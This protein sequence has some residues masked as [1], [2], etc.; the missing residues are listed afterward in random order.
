MDNAM[1]LLDE[2]KQFVRKRTKLVPDLGVILGSGLGSF[3]DTVEEAVVV[4]YGELPG[5]PLSTA[6]G[7]AGRLIL[8]R[9]GGRKVAIM[10]GRFHFYEG[11]SM[12]RVVL[13][14]RLLGRL[15]AP[16]VIVT[17]AAGGIRSDLAPGDLML[18]SDH[19]NLMGQNPLVG[20]NIDVLGPRFPDMSD[21]Y[22]KSLREQ[23]QSIAQQLGIELKEGVF[24]ALSGPSYETPAEIN[25]LRLIGADA[26]AMST[27]PEVIA[28]RHMNMRVLGISCI[29]NLAAGLSKQPLSHADVTEIANRTQATFNKLLMGLIAHLT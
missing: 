7:H 17:N 18:I 16:T 11:Y 3:A 23:A 20:P 5:F 12:D 8:G 24:A 6:P 25:F 1:D 22:T 27:V 13:G 10:Q 9:L 19:I 26:V 29:S 15:G 21:A 28:A 2:G 4:G 14:V